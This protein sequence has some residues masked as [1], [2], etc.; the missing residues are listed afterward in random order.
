[1]KRI[2]IPISNGKLSEFF[3]QCDYY[4]I[5]DID[6]KKIEK[7]QEILFPAKEKMENMPDWIADK[8][9]SDLVSYKIDNKIIKMFINNKIN[10]YIGIPIKTPV[11]IVNDYINGNLKSDGKVISEITN[12]KK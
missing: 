9:I 6:L 8:G 11:E 3:G 10:L 1:M 4:K 5:Y 7:E 12:N 2:A